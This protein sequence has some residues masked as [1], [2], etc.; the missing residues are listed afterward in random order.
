MGGPG[1]EVDGADALVPAEERQREQAAHPLLAAL[2]REARPP[3][4]ADDEVGDVVLGA[5]AGGVEAGSL[6]ERVLHGV[7]LEGLDR[8]VRGGVRA[9]GA[10]DGDPDL[11][12]AVDV[13]AHR[14]DDALEVLGHLLHRLQDPAEVGR[15]GRDEGLL[16]D[17]GHR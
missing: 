1:V 10:E 2:L 12:A 15:E 4:V 3:A 16:V 6:V 5:V 7:D 14:V 8:R 13:A 11:V 9:V 17:G